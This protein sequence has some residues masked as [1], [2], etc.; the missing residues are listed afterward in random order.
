MALLKSL[1]FKGTL[2]GSAFSKDK[3]YLLRELFI[4]NSIAVS[5]FQINSYV[6]WPCWVAT[7]LFILTTAGFEVLIPLVSKNTNSDIKFDE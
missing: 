7:G 5:C 2:V 6:I 1:F 3:K 4:L